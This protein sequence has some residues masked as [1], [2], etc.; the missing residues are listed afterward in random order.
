MNPKFHGQNN[1]NCPVCGQWPE[2]EQGSWN[3]KITGC[4]HLVLNGASGDMD[5]R[6][7]RAALQANRA[8]NIPGVASGGWPV[9]TK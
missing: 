9:S 5:E 6:D 3:W 7:V 4:E 2:V 1:G 8:W